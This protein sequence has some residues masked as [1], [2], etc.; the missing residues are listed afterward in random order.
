MADELDPTVVIARDMRALPE[1]TRK[2]VRPKIRKAG[3]IVAGDAKQ[4]ADW[5]SRI[6]GTVR[7]RTSF[8]ADREKVQVVAGG[9]GAPHARPYEGIATQGDSFRHPVHGNREVWVSQ[10]K[11]PF[12]FPAAEAKGEEVTGLIRAALDDAAQGIG[13]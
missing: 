13:F 6:P 4:R 11:R 7:V 10:D 12:I 8:Q 3:E 9:A 1:E 5:S 2:A